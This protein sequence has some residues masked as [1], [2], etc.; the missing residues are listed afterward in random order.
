MVRLIRSQ[1]EG[2][3][4]WHRLDDRGCGTTGLVQPERD[5]QETAV[6]D[7][8]LG[9]FFEYAEKHPCPNCEWEHH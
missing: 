2:A 4:Y 6:E 8:D 5:E 3:R 7:A 1:A 9:A